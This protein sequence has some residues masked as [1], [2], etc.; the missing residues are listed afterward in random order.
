MP[1]STRS[2]GRWSASCTTIRTASMPNVWP[3]PS[4]RSNTTR[5][6]SANS[7][8]LRTARGQDATK[9]HAPGERFRLTDG[10]DRQSGSCLS[11]ARFGHSVVGHAGQ[12]RLLCGTIGRDEDCS[13]L[14]P[15]EGTAMYYESYYERPGWWKTAAAVAIGVA[16]LGALA[17]WQLR[18]DS[19]SGDAAS[20]SVS[21]SGTTIADR[22]SSDTSSSTTSAT[23]ATTATPGGTTTSSDSS[24]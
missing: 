20:T 24:A 18:S 9:R 23:P 8:H 10:L 7:R 16:L 5:T 3:P 12:Q 2:E 4:R 13:L 22:S 14:E 1:R 15:I 21:V 17:F 19:G 11:G 6:S